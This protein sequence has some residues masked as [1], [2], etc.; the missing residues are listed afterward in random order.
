[1]LIDTG[2]KRC[3]GR[4]GRFVI[5]LSLH[6]QLHIDSNTPVE[7][8]MNSNNEIVLR[9]YHQ[10]CAICGNGN[11]IQNMGDLILCDNCIENIRSCPIFE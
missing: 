7:I 9:V 4:A 6:E 8:Y 11:N 1:M 5:P 10:A 3:V 2:M